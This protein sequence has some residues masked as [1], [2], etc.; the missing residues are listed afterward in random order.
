MSLSTLVFSF[1]FLNLKNFWGFLWNSSSS[2][3][4]SGQVISFKSCWGFTWTEFLR[5]LKRDEGRNIGWRVLKIDI[6]FEI[7]RLSVMKMLV[8]FLLAGES[9]CSLIVHRLG[10]ESTIS[11]CFR[12]A[13]LYLEV[14]G[15]HLTLGVNFWLIIRS[16]SI[17][18]LFE[19]SSSF[20]VLMVVSQLVHLLENMSTSQY[21]SLS[22]VVKT[23][24]LKLEVIVDLLL[25][26]LADCVLILL[27]SNFPVPI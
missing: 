17:E 16:R 26:G 20:F 2:F 15:R 22:K 13:C 3:K 6:S 11:K 18:P 24:C 4:F 9:L 21:R 23:F 12:W 25:F 27:K 7:F 19:S 10:F 8:S 14:K 1:V 5:E